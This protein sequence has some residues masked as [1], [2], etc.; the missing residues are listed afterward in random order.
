MLFFLLINFSPFASASD[1]P[2]PS[3]GLQSQPPKVHQI[4]IYDEIWQKPAQNPRV[5][6]I[7]PNNCK[8]S[9]IV[10]VIK[11]LWEKSFYMMKYNKTWEW[12]QTM[13]E[14]APMVSVKYRRARWASS[15]TVLSLMS[16]TSVES[17][18]PLS[19]EHVILLKWLPFAVTYNQLPG[20]GNQHQGDPSIRTL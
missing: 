11:S 2:Q 17:P 1:Q 15:T 7:S 3:C 9:E 20:L 16:V 6:K 13:T 14:D 10:K 12:P 5:S 19:D 18:K 4:T 8:K